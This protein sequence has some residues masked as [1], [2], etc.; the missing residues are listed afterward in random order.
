M[1]EEDYIL[2][3][4]DLDL[5]DVNVEIFR[6]HKVVE[7]WVNDILIKKITPEYKDFSSVEIRNVDKRCE[8]V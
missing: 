1:S 4:N 3:Y 5:D 7:I 6:K 8:D 2:K